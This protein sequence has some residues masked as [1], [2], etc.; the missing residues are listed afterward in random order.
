MQR[1]IGAGLGALA[2]YVLLILFAGTAQSQTYLVAVIV[3]LAI[4]ILWPWI[5]TLMVARRV[6]DRRKE[7]I[8]RE[9]QEALT[10]KS[11]EG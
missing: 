5:I 9:V 4:S 10:Q 11:R 6:K 2:T 1:I 7:E 3:G 8:D